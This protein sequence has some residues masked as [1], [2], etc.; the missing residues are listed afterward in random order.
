[1]ERQD[2]R[3]ITL[4]IGILLVLHVVGL[5]GFAL[6]EWAPFF[7]ILTPFHLLISIG[8]M[9]FFHKPW[10][11]KLLGFGLTI[12]LLGWG[13]EVIGVQ[14]K[15]IFGAYAYTGL[16]GWAP[17]GVPLL[18]GLNWAALVYS[19]GM[20]FLPFAWSGVIKALLGGILLVLFDLV[21]EP[22]A[23]GIGLWHWEG[24]IP[25]QNYL[26]WLI[27]AF[28]FLFFFHKLQFQKQNPLALPFILIQGSFFLIGKILGF[29]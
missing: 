29:W 12:I 1:M 6:P 11:K 22:F 21:L 7:K 28:T 8:V 4:G 5:A 15:A 19:A 17:F 20:I 26:A 10:N 9:A 25:V 3:L 27:I 18:I 16:L 13:I 24:G 23:T 14:T 2:Y